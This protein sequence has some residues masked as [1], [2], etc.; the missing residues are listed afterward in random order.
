MSALVDG[1]LGLP[2]SVVLGL[3]FLIPALEASSLLGVVLPGEVT[4]LLGGVVA[5]Q[6]RLSLVEVVA[7]AAA[8]AVIGDNIGF[9]IGR[10]YGVTLTAR[11]PRWLLKPRDVDRAMSLARRLGGG[12]VVVGRF[13]S[14][15]RTLIPGLAGM[16]GM[17]YREF[18][19]Y[20]L[21]GGVL[22]AAAVA[23]LGYL[24]GAGYRV[25]EQRLGVGGEILAGLVV[26]A[27]LAALLRTR[28]R[29]S[30]DHPTEAS[31]PGTA[32]GNRRPPAS[33]RG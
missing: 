4:V 8:G 7:A 20:N 5:H 1:L 21:A 6:G 19:V 10:R 26:L 22:W 29:R 11:V 9:L 2:P 16:G 12:A 13:V 28:R 18:A 31:R 17:R 23:F 15:L 33:H 32:A 14:P 27:G 25:V 30:A 3:V 24:A